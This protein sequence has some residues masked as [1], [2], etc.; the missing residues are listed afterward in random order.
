MA[1][2]TSVIRT[3]RLRFVNNPATSVN[4]DAPAFLTAPPPIGTQVTPGVVQYTLRA[5]N[6]SLAGI[7]TRGIEHTQQGTC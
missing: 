5:S 6:Q 1:L 3:T 7:L 4:N 2:R